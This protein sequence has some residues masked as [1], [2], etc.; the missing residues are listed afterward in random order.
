M[1]APWYSNGAG[2]VGKGCVGQ[3]TSPGMSVSVGTGR[4]SI[5]HTGSPVTR[6]KTY[7]NPCLLTWA[8]ALTGR[9]ATSMSTRFGA[10]GKS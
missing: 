9:P 7:T 4:S 6:S 3:T 5:G 10:A 1:A 2:R 8:S